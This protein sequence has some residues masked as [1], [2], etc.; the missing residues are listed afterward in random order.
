MVGLDLQAKYQ[1]EVDEETKPWQLPT[2]LY[3]LGKR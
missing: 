1:A 2:T 3:R